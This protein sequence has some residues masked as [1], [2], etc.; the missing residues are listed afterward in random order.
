MDGR[1]KA[2]SHKFADPNR[3]GIFLPLNSVGEMMAE[4]LPRSILAKPYV[5][6]RPIARVAQRI[7]DRHFHPRCSVRR[8][9]VAA[10]DYRLARDISGVVSR[11][12]FGASIEQA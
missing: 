7:Y 2:G 4:A 11:A 12:S 9:A 10:P 5:S 6:V 1:E 3:A 8:G